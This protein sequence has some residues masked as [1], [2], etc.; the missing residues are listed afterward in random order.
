MMPVVYRLGNA[1]VLP[2]QG[3]GETWGLSVNEAMACG[4]PVLVSNRCG[5]AFDL[6]KDNGFIFESNNLNALLEQMQ[7]LFAERNHWAGNGN[8]SNQSISQFHYSKIADIL[9]ASI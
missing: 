5:C 7:K 8:K 1:F 9:E 6:V 4:L 2:S 3:P